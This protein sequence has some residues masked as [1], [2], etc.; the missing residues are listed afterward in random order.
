MK[1]V[2]DSNGFKIPGLFRSPSGSL[3][4]NNELALAKNKLSFNA[5]VDMR[6]EISELRKKLDKVVALVSALNK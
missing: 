5:F 2:V 3:I 4:V 6:T 1:Q